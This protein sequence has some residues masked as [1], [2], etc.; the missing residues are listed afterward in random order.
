MVTLRR[1]MPRN[2][3]VEDAESVEGAEDALHKV[4]QWLTKEVR[5][6]P[7]IEGEITI[8][9]IRGTKKTDEETLSE[10]PFD[11]TDSIE[12]KAAEV[13]DDADTDIRQLNVASV[14]YTVTAENVRKRLTFTLKMSRGDEE[15]EDLDD[16]ME[17]TRQGIVGLLMNHQHVEFKDSRK[18]RRS[19]M[20]MFQRELEKKDKRIADLERQQMEVIKMA[21]DLQQGRHVREMEIRKLENGERRKEKVVD[22]LMNAL[23]ILAGKIMGGGQGAHE[24]SKGAWT[25]LEQMMYGLFGSLD[26]EQMM[27]IAQ[28]GLFTMEQLMALKGIGDMIIEREEAEKRE[29]DAANGVGAS[30]PPQDQTQETSS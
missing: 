15:L 4:I 24:L 26:R 20:Q 13:V 8:L 29:R 9:L 23:P 28:S 7:E 19:L 14:R 17:P 16:I 5:E 12:D 25:P 27:R 3:E 1:T 11:P 30:S 2:E 22:V 18:E 6:S 21:E 10:I